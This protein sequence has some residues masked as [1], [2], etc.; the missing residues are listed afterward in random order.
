MTIIENTIIEDLKEMLSELIDLVSSQFEALK[1]ALITSPEEDSFSSEIMDYE[2]RINSLELSIDRECERFMAKFTPVASDLRLVI[3]ILKSTIFLERMGDNAERIVNYIDELGHSY[4]KEVIKQVELDK[5]IDLILEMLSYLNEAYLEMDVQKARKAYHL[6]KKVNKIN[7]AN[8]KAIE[9]YLTE[10][11]KYTKECL[12]LF[13]T[14]KKLERT[15]DYCKHITE[16]LIF[17][18]NAKTM[19]HKKVKKK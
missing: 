4:S 13:S 18:I 8:L 6:D 1:N 10:N 11:P 5:M 9:K 19:R 17:Y 7:L 2:K 15:G 12:Y 14:S 16:E 3:S